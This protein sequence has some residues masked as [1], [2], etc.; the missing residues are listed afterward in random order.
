MRD[1]PSVDLRFDPARAA[2]LLIDFQERLA[3]AMPADDRDACVRNIRV[4]LAMAA[5]LG[6]P[7]VVSEQYP[8]GLGPTVAS[9]GEALAA[10]GLRVERLEKLEFACTENAAWDGIAARVGRTQ[11]TVCGVEAH[12]CV[13]QTARGLLERGLSVHVPVDAVA[14]RVPANKRVGLDL[15]GRAGAVLTATEVLVTDA[16]GRAGTDDF[17]ALMSL[18]K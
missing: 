1:A 8:K 7:V 18:L 11:W 14:A 6:L 15:M 13:Y 9:L 2:V 16:L 12:V 4:L 17:R 5:R 3:A 10:P